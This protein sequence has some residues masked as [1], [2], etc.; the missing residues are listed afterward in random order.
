M[1]FTIN[2]K[3]FYIELTEVTIMNQPKDKYILYLIESDNY[4]KLVASYTY[5]QLYRIAYR[6]ATHKTISINEVPQFIENAA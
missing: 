1:R 2:G 4:T 6:V 5:P 3:R